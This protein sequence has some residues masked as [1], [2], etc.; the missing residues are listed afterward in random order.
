MQR[1]LISLAA[2]AA[3]FGLGAAMAQQ[4]APPAPPPA[5]PPAPQVDPSQGQEVSETE[6]ET[7]VEIYVDLQET[8][9]KFQTE[10]SAAETEQE[11]QE[12]QVQ[13]QQESIEKISERG[14]TPEKYTSVADAVNSDP[15]LLERALALIEQRS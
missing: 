7:F 12:V 15:T 1:T 11:A 8:A 5:Q 10:M 13:M 14:W 6:L 2:A 3:V 9:E 4:P